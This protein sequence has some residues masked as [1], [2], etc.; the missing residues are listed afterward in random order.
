MNLLWRCVLAQAFQQRHAFGEVFA[1]YIQDEGIL[2]RD[3]P[4]KTFRSFCEA[5]VAAVL[6]NRRR[7][8][9]VKNIPSIHTTPFTKDSVELPSRAQVGW[10]LQLRVF[11]LGGNQD[12]KVWVGVFPE[13]E[14]I[15]MGCLSLGGVALQSVGACQS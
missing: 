12:K 13:C 2:L 3:Y 8:V 7:K 6:R 14:E 11:G 4:N 15:L 1:H 10:S 5:A 9:C